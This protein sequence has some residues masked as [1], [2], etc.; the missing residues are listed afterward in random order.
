MRISTSPTSSTHKSLREEIKSVAEDVEARG[1]VDDS[2]RNCIP[3]SIGLMLNNVR[4][5]DE[6]NRMRDIL[7]P[8]PLD[9]RVPDTRNR[10]RTT[11]SRDLSG[12]DRRRVGGAE[13]LYGLLW[14]PR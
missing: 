2:K 9:G 12:V 4:L 5:R 14:A 8:G 7:G 13:F 1:D 11:R 6:L 3:R 10:S